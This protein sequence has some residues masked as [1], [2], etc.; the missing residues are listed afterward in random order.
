MRCVTKLIH[1][2]DAIQFEAAIE[3]NACVTR[4]C[5]RIARHGYHLS[6]LASGELLRLRLRALPRWVEYDAIDLP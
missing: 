4:E 6:D 3:K 5:R 1:G 2:R